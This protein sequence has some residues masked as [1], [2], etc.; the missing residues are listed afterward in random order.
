MPDNTMRLFLGVDGGQ[1]STVALIGDETG[2]VVGIGRGAACRHE[3][4]IREAVNAAG[5]A[6]R[7]FEAACF[8]LSGGASG[9]EPAL[10]ELV[11]AD[12]YVVTHD[13][14]IAL[15]GALAREPGIIVIAGTGSMAFGRN[16]AGRST[17]AGGWGYAFGD[18]GGAFDLVR[19]GL[20]AAL[21]Q[22]EGWGPPTALRELLLGASDAEDA[23]ELMHRFY[24]AGWPRERIAALAPLLDKAAE[25]GDIV[26]QEILQGAAQAL[27]I[28]A[29]VVR[30]QLFEQRETAV[31][32]YTGGVFRSPVVLERFHML[33]ELGDE[34]QAPRYGPAAGAL[35][36]AY[37]AAGVDVLPKD[38]QMEKL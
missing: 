17:R 1:S 6:G 19:Q 33:V 2:H 34:V 8:G 13:A 23:N 20:R 14:A 28:I 36:E 24:T 12:R 16:T 26:A 3:G 31:V 21:R 9:R 25:G 27:A 22:E 37:R 11:K 10:R 32:S 35:I 7:R 5:A 18:E 38:V 4:A 29:G 15:T 30:G